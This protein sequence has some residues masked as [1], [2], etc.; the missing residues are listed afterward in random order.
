M[1]EITYSIAI[2][3]QVQVL[4]WLMI[5]GFVDPGTSLPTK[6]ESTKMSIGC[7]DIL[8][9][10]S[11]HIEDYQ[12]ECGMIR[13]MN[14]LVNPAD[15]SILKESDNKTF[16]LSIESSKKISEEI[17]SLKNRSIQITPRVQTEEK[18]DLSVFN[19]FEGVLV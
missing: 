12:Y 16:K 13:T 19:L 5:N 10:L 2:E 18:V 14:A 4:S 15:K 11:K 3:L 9:Q 6:K 17:R 8:R 1:K 7:R